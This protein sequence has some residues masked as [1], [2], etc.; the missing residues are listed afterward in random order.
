MI[1]TILVSPETRKT[2]QTEN[3]WTGPHPIRPDEEVLIT[4]TPMLAHSQFNS[5]SASTAG[6]VTLTEAPADGSIILADIVIS[7]EKRNGG[8]VTIQWNDG[9]RQILI[10]RAI[11][12]DAPVN[13]SISFNGRVQGWRDASL[14][15]V[16]VSTTVNTVFCSYAKYR[17]GLPF[18]EWDSYR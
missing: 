7:T 4:T 1:Q 13:Q 5:V 8:S 3:F 17:D 18:D 10:F 2:L 14:E 15:V 16:T 12:T 6:T 9:I 11:C